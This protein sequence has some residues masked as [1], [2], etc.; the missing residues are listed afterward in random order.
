[1]FLLSFFGE[2]TPVEKV[3]KVHFSRT[4]YANSYQ[5]SCL[6]QGAV[7][8]YLGSKYF[9]RSK[10]VSYWQS[11]MMDRGYLISFL[12]HLASFSSQA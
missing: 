8:V 9:T 5:P 10:E 4:F 7:M 3:A 2:K 12:Y 6:C 1:M 11:N